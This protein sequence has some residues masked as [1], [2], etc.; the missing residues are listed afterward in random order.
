MKKEKLMFDQMDSQEKP[1]ENFEASRGWLERF[2][3]RNGLSLRRRTSIAQKDPEQLVNKLVSYI[4]QAR[5]LEMKCKFDPSNIYAMDE[6]PVWSDM[7]GTTTVTRKGSS[8]VVLK[9]IGHEKARVSVCL[10]AKADGT[11]MKPF[12][13]FKGAKREV[14]KLNDEFRGRC[15]VASSENGWM[16]TPLT[17]EWIQKIL[18]SFSFNKHLLAWDSYEC[19]ITH[20]I[21]EELKSK[22]IQP[23]IIPGGCTKYVQ[24]PDVCWNKPFKAKRDLGLKGFYREKMRF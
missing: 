8:E 9:S 16:N 2:M 10:T 11:K 20:S 23:V 13:V 14:A 4:L 7:V 6:T 18:G 3:K 1:E 22:K 5:R 15:L 17:M 19:H 24:A 21:S 12:I